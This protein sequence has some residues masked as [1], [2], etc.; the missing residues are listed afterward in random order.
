MAYL[1][2][3]SLDARESEELIC[4]ILTKAKDDIEEEQKKPHLLAIY[5]GEIAVTV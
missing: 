2:C 5:R 1:K 3:L 4:E